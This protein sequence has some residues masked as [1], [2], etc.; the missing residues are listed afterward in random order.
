[1]KLWHIVQWGNPEE[2][3]DGDDAQCIISASSF[4]SAV[5]MAEQYFQ[6]YNPTYM[7][8]KCHVVHMMGQD[9]KPDGAAVMVIYRWLQPAVNPSKMAYWYRHIH[10][11]EWEEVIE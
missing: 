3:G 9:D 5:I 6:D 7:N 1:M 10:S 2:G 4:E 8:G 11:D